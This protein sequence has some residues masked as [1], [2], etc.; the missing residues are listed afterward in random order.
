MGFRRAETALSLSPPSHGSP[1]VARE[2]EYVSLGAHACSNW[3]RGVVCRYTLGAEDFGCLRGKFGT[4]RRTLV[5]CA[6]NTCEYLSSAG[7]R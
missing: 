7:K 6:R 4:F 3:D 5:V 1:S 2:V